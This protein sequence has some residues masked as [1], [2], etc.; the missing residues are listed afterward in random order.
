[1][2]SLYSLKLCTIL[3]VCA[4]VLFIGCES[5]PVQIDLGE[6]GHQLTVYTTDSTQF[7]S[8]QMPNRI[9][10]SSS[11]YVGKINNKRSTAFI[12]LNADVFSQHSTLCSEDIDSL[13]LTLNINYINGYTVANEPSVPYQDSINTDINFPGFIEN[14]T[15]ESNILSAFLFN[16][17]DFD[18]T[19][20]ESSTIDVD[21]TNGDFLLDGN[22][23]MIDI[24]NA[25][26]L[27]IEFTPSGIHILLDSVSVN[28]AE[29]SGINNTICTDDDNESIWIYLKSTGD[30]LFVFGSANNSVISRLPFVTGK[31]IQKEIEF[32]EEHKIQIESISAGDSI[33]AFLTIQ[34]DTELPEFGTIIG[35]PFDTTT[36]ITIEPIISWVDTGKTFEVAT[37]YIQPSFHEKDS[38]HLIEFSM[39]NPIF[40]YRNFDPSGDNYSASDTT[41]SED[42]EY[43]DNGEL[44]EDCGSD[45]L[46]NEDEA[47]YNPDGTEKNG[48]YDFG[49]FFLDCGTDSLCNDN[50][51][52]SSE[53]CDSIGFEWDET[54]GCLVSF[55][56]E[57]DE[58]EDDFI[59]DPVGDD[60]RDCGTD[61][62]CP[63]DDG[64]IN[65]DLDSTEN[66]GVWDDGEGLENNNHWDAGEPFLDYGINAIPDSL[67]GQN[68][69]FDNFN[70]ND[71]TGT[72]G[73][74]IWDQGEW[75]IDA[76]IDTTWSD[77]ED[78]YN[79]IGTEGNGEYDYGEIFFDFGID[80]LP[81]SLE[82]GYDEFTNPDPSN[83]NLNLDPMEDDWRDCGID[84]ICP[85]DDNYEQADEGEFNG[86]FDEGEK[87]EGNGILNFVDVNEDS[88]LGITDSSEMWFDWGIDQLEDTTELY[89]GSYPLTV[90]LGTNL[91]AWSDTISEDSIITKP[92]LEGAED[93]A[94]WISKIHNDS[95]ENLIELTISLYSLSEISAFQFQL[96]HIPFYHEDTVYT[97]KSDDIYYVNSLRLIEDISMYPQSAFTADDSIAVNFGESVYALLDFPELEFFIAE[98]PDVII[99]DA[100]VTVFPDSLHKQNEENF[101][102]YL[103]R[104]TEAFYENDDSLSSEYI[105]DFPYYRNYSS[106]PDSIQL[107]VK[108]YIQNLVSDG[109]GYHKLVFSTDGAGN[110]FDN[111]YFKNDSTAVTRLEILYTK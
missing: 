91:V 67:E 96:D 76:G 38:T 97:D 7:H 33:E 49:E 60:W 25:I 101:R 52:I 53:M 95:I 59:I 44:F 35:L 109:Y 98:N 77:D 104:L 86:N 56:G 54:I 64:Y 74:G 78:G 61:G 72:E 62:L 88:L 31:Y 105:L 89:F 9:G 93:V 111:F 21:T 34:T 42:N 80:R 19:W 39:E 3:S 90:D 17:S 27:P 68:Y 65:A 92:E 63:D 99:S 37:L 36:T 43:Y 46:C 12:K 69:E 29:Y 83:D 73:N 71:S 107:S 81:D 32:Q 14:Y 10:T 102:L 5:E 66:N 18:I 41:G 48:Q 100:L 22:S 8:V 58:S 13:K 70:P 79:N 85:G 6:N 20:N 1:M 2:S 15:P 26:E 11:L 106:A 47:G 103:S 45:L 51:F 82:N 30:S 75:F 24:E 84:G 108:R 23:M 28:N 40:V 16:Q 57:N 94:L 55:E 4:V 50:N 87:W 110:N